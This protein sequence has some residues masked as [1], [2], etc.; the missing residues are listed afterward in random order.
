MGGVKGNTMRRFVAAGVAWIF[1]TL[2]VAAIAVVPE[3][4][5]AGPNIDYLVIVDGPNGTGSWVSGRS[6]VFG[7]TDA[8]WAA[9]YNTTSGYV[10]DVPSYWY[11]RS[12]PTGTDSVIWTNT[13]YG[14]SVRVHAAGYGT[15][16]LRAYYY[17]GN[18]TYPQNETG[19][20]H[21]SVDNVD[22][23]VIRSDRGGTGTWVGPT[24]YEVGDRDV[25]YAAAYNATQAFLGDIFSNWTS[26]NT[27]VGYVY[28]QSPAG[29][30]VGGN[31]TAGP[32]YPLG[33][34][35]ALAFGFTFVTPEPIG[36]NLSNT[37]GKLT[38]TGVTIDDVV[39]PDAPNGH[40]VA[41][42]NRTYYPR[43]QDT[44]YAA[45][46]NRTL[47]Y[48]GDVVGDWTSND[49]AVCEP[50]GFYQGTAHGSSVQILLKAAGVCAITVTATT[51]SGV[52][53]NATGPLT[54]LP[55]S[56]ITV[57][58]SGGADFL[59]VQEGVDAAGAGYT[60]FVYD[61]I[62]PE[63]VVV[64]KELEIVG[65]TRDGVKI[66][67]GGTGTTLFVGADRVVVHTLTVQGGAFGVFQDRTNNTRLYDTTIRDYGTGLYNNRTLNAWVA[68]NLITR[69]AI[70]VVAYKA[71]D[72]AI[73]WNEISF[74]TVYGAKGYNARL[75][76]CFNWN[77]LH[78]NKIGY[79][80]DPTT[81]LPPYEFDG[82]VL[83]GN[84]IGV[85]VEDSSA[86]VV[87]NNQ[88]T[89]GS[90][91]VQLINS[92]SE[93]RG[94]T[95][96]A[97]LTGIEFRLSSSNLTGN[98]ITAALGITGRGGAPRIEGND[99]LA[100]GTAMDLANLDGAIVRGNDVHGG[101]IP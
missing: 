12:Y 6:Y 9:G 40:G 35:Y 5:R 101:T 49:T 37:T 51:V 4:A 38:V 59:T 31:G 50:K 69:G 88:V 85:R 1:L 32:C 95:I 83:A 42:G 26:S 75:R 79:F 21:V 66:D 11:A 3:R 90:V 10:A 74:N 99:V 47:G 46:Y 98:T 24:T 41:L 65:E 34:F 60:I 36:T 8:F 77:W 28:P 56:V 82:N 53:T 30:C 87:T 64:P 25:F 81:D 2:L 22:S 61:G 94:N 91:A 13:S 92:S 67:G 100:T 7:D 45:S 52:K 55:R 43:E 70:G 18:R 62:Y 20:L 16:T 23:V 33:I 73:R 17:G 54:V 27:T 86:M 44:F 48:R 80:Y 57:D 14:P 72:D 19:P 84:E 93:V 58:G 78:D 89:G 68:H 63:H 15:T 97:A 76:N 71:Y 96:T 39:I 29:Q